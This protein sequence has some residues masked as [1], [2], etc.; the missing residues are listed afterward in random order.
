[1]KRKRRTSKS[2]TAAS[3]QLP[4][5][6]FGKLIRSLRLKMGMSQVS[7]G[8]ELDLHP[9]YVSRMEHGERR[10]SPEVLKRMSEM[11]GCPLDHLLVVSG[12][13]DDSLSGKQVTIEKV[14]SLR[15]EVEQLRRRVGEIAQAEVGTKAPSGRR[16]PMRSV[17]VFDAMPAGILLPSAK[18][19]TKALKTLKLP[20]KE[21]KDHPDAFALVAT[22]DSM[23]DAGILEGDVVVISPTAKVKSGDIAVVALRGRKASVKTVYLEGDKVLLQEANRNYRP[24][25]L[26]YPK[27]VEIIGKAVLIWRKLG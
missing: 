8:E 25:V 22:G 7:L 15:K 16:P 3:V 12:L 23:I 4:Y 14:V 20:E 24:I 19:K 10:A 13:T 5:V 6:E 9:S 27:D 18:G 2:K 17:P 11:L 26:D 21:L 1:M